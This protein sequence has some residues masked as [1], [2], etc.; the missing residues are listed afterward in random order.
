LMFMY[1]HMLRKPPPTPKSNPKPTADGSAQ[2]TP[3][4]SAQPTPD[5]SANNHAEEMK[6]HTEAMNIWTNI[7]ISNIMFNLVI[8]Y[9]FC[10]Y[11]N[12]EMAVCIS[13]KI[14]F[15]VNSAWE[16]TFL[17]NLVHGKK[18]YGAISQEELAFALCFG[19]VVMVCSWVKVGVLFMNKH[20]HALYEL[21][22]WWVLG[23]AY[24]VLMV[25]FYR[26][27]F[28]VVVAWMFKWWD[29]AKIFY[30]TTIQNS[31]KLL[32]TMSELWNVVQEHY[33][34]QI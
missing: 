8:F 30:S 7:V 17:T 3:D 9:Q 20:K 32:K 26:N 1:W 34:R 21:V 24:T 25:Y 23:F 27:A 16:G 33:Q 18:N 11:H 6:V 29:E 28:V 31:D 4:G 12:A 13:N 15:W 19:L 10:K 22:A 5:G 14:W 2:P